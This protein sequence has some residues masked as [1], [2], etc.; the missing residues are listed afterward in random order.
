MNSPLRL[1]RLSLAN[2]GVLLMV[3]VAALGQFGASLSGPVAG[4]IFDGRGLRP[5]QGILGSAT[6]GRP[7]ELGFVL[8]KAWVLDARHV[9]VS[10]EASPELLTLNMETKP[11][12]TA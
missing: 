10:T 4:Y 2:A 8:S 9:I 3:S 5:V 1:R 12:L 11:V 7:I 6:V